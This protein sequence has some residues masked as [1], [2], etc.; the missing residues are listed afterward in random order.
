MGTQTPKNN[1]Y[2]SVLLLGDGAVPGYWVS[3]FL[4]SCVPE[5]TPQVSCMFTYGNAVRRRHET[6]L[7]PETD[8]GPFFV[9]SFTWQITLIKIKPLQILA[10]TLTPLCLPTPICSN[11]LYPALWRSWAVFVP[12]SGRCFCQISSSHED[13]HH[14][15]PLLSPMRALCGA[16]IISI[17]I[18]YSKLSFPKVVTGRRLTYFVKTR[19]I[20]C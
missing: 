7:R 4:T 1:L 11:L 8:Y 16:Q 19:H 20:I 2:V 13:N 10:F 3:R 6:S 15:C 5:F 14:H 17:N 9:I 18:S 12:T